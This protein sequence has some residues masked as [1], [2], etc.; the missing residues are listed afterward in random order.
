MNACRALRHSRTAIDG[1]CTKNAA[2]VKRICRRILKHLNKGI[3]CKLRYLLTILYSMFRT[4]FVII[5]SLPNYSCFILALQT[6]TKLTTSGPLKGGFGKSMSSSLSVSTATNEGSGNKEST[7][8]DSSSSK[9][10]YFK[11]MIMQSLMRGLLNIILYAIKFI[12]HTYQIQ[13]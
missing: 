13:M 10:F 8:G 2:S 11:L 12:F 7:V 3:Y 9:D 6:L 1:S 5:S 4:I